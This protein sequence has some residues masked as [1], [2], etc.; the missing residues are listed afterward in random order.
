MNMRTEKEYFIDFIA[1]RIGKTWY[2]RCTSYDTILSK[3]FTR[4]R[5]RY[6]SVVRFT[7]NGDYVCGYLTDE[8]GY[9]YV[10]GKGFSIESFC[11]LVTNEL[12]CSTLTA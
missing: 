7:R 4:N 5:K 9:A 1:K 2:I 12:K 6:I 3:K 10:N 8:H 11:N